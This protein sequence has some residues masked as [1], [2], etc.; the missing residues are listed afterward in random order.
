MILLAL[1]LT[2][3]FQLLLTTFYTT[4]YET[5]TSMGNKVSSTNLG[6]YFSP[7]FSLC[8]GSDILT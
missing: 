8:Y 5:A 2:K 1:I 3:N 7:Y 4:D 6:S